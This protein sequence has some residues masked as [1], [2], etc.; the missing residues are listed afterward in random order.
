MEAPQHEGHDGENE[1]GAD[2]ARGEALDALWHVSVGVNGKDSRIY[3]ETSGADLESIA[4]PDLDVDDGSL[5]YW[6]EVTQ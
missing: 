5:L 6:R 1:Q 2:D 4:A 3:I